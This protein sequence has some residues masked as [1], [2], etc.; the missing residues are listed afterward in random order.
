MGRLE[1]SEVRTFKAEFGQELVESLHL[2]L[3]RCLVDTV[4]K[5]DLLFPGQPGG[6]FVGGEHEFL[7]DALGL[8]PFTGHYSAA[9]SVFVDEQLALSGVYVRGMPLHTLLDED[10]GQLVHERYL[11]EYL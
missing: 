8:A 1:F 6:G 2:S 11:A 7:Y 9:D 5:R 3:R 4:H 10:V